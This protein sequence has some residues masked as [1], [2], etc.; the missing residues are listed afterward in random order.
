VLSIKSRQKKHR[1]K[2]YEDLFELQVLP[3][4]PACVTSPV[5]QVTDKKKL[6]RLIE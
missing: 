1:G 3:Q 4:L 2:A 5:I 6:L